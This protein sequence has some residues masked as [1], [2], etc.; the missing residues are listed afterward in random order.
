VGGGLSRPK[1]I[2]TISIGTGQEYK[3]SAWT[4][5]GHK[6]QHT[7]TLAALCYKEH[8]MFQFKRIALLMQLYQTIETV[9]VSSEIC[10][11]FI[12]FNLPVVL[13]W[14]RHF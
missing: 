4:Q 12:A 5:P 11:P 1:K 14:A 7:V 8:Q 13:I 2:S 3:F 10:L 9:C 6:R